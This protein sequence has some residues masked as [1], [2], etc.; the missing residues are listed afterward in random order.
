MKKTGETQWKQHKLRGGSE[1]PREGKVKEGKSLSEEGQD[2][3]EEV[4]SGAR[5]QSCIF[6]GKKEWTQVE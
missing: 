3:M 4:P 5:K 1:G 6:M 2:S